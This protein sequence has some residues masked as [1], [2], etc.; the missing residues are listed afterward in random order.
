MNKFK[1]LA[2]E[3][4]SSKL[5]V[6]DTVKIDFDEKKSKI[7]MKVSKSK[8]NTSPKTEDE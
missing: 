5:T 6:G 1:E 3:I 2:E 8:K 4:L 7:I